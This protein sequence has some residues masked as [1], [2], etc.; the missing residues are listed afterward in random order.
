M[1]IRFKLSCTLNQES[2][3]ANFAA[4]QMY[5]H[6][7]KHPNSTHDE[8][9]HTYRKCCKLHANSSMTGRLLT[10]GGVLR[11]AAPEVIIPDYKSNLKIALKGL[12]KK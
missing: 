7:L 8:Q 10:Y 5:E 12:D 11:P 4:G 6:Q 2:A 9:Y 3:T 1:H